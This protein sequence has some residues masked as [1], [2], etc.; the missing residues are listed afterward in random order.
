ML[1]LKEAGYGFKHGEIITKPIKV[2]GKVFVYWPWCLLLNV[3]IVLS[4]LL[5]FKAEERRVTLDLIEIQ[6]KHA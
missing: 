2:E 5:V 3:F 1:K 4:L 6:N